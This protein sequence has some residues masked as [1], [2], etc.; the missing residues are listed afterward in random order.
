MVSRSAASSTV[1][2]RAA[3]ADRNRCR[4]QAASEPVAR[5]VWQNSSSRGE[6]L[7]PDRAAPV[8]RDQEQQ[9][10]VVA[11]PRVDPVVVEEVAQV[12]QD[13]AGDPVGDVGGVAGDQ[14]RPAA[15]RAAAAR[16][17]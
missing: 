14:G 1:V 15:T 17:T 10:E 6:G 11:E 2:P 3:Q 9:A 4:I 7:Q 12:V 8:Q 16:R 13:W 5:R